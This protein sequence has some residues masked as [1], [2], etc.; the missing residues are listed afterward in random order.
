MNTNTHNRRTSTF[1]QRA[2]P[3][4]AIVVL[5]IGLGGCQ[6]PRGEAVPQVPA[7]Q[8]ADAPVSH[9]LGRVADRIE[10]ELARQAQAPATTFPSWTARITAELE[11]QA[12]L[13]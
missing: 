1:A 12:Q 4:L 10:A 9:E 3:A 8:K 6:T 11:Y 5:A 2:V 13:S 7:V